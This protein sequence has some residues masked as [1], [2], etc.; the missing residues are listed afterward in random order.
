M[1]LVILAGG[2][3]TR[4][5]E[6][7]IDKPKPLVEIGGYP[8]IWHIMKIY[9]HYGINDFVI[10]CGYKGY[11]LKEYFHNYLIHSSN[12]TIETKDN[13]VKIHKNDEIDWKITLVDTGLNSM[14]G[15]RILRIK[16]YVDDTFCMTYGDGLGNI[17]ISKLIDFHNSH[18]KLATMTIVRPA[19]RFGSVEV[20][21]NNNVKK[22]VEKIDLGNT[23]YNGG[24]FVLNKGIFDYI[25]EDSTIWEEDPLKGMVSDNNLMAYKHEDFWQPM[26]TM[27]ERDILEKLW[28]QN[29]APWKVWK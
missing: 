12:V 11:L 26:D 3:G 1:K 27:R 13:K 4:I 2:K 7:S 16:D 21:T 23:W 20:D 18:K 28:I 6:E 25:K 8:I 9:S 29:K 10:C 22:F 24:F 17:N 19:P 5:S 15:G 14:T